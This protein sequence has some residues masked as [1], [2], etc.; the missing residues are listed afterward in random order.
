MC[1]INA[2]KLYS[3]GGVIMFELG[4]LGTR[5]AFYMDLVT[6]YFA[7]LPFLLAL[8]IRQAVIGNISMHY[9]SQMAILALT[10]VMV[11]IFEIGVRISGGF[12]EYVKAS[13]VSY[14]FLLFFLLVHILVAFLSVV[15]WIYLI[16][17]SYRTYVKEGRE[18]MKKHRK[19]GKWIFA[20]LTL[21][22]IMGCSIYV[23]LFLM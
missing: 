19:M 17:T 20:S 21:T 10:V 1:V 18:G 2:I 6:V 5:A 13:P 11:L 12:S 23:F 16:V 22:S 15:G 14:D 3:V 4:F 7:I 8:S 9:K